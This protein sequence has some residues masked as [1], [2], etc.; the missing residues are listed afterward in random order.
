M[1]SPHAPSPASAGDPGEGE[2]RG[3]ST[4]S[5]ASS[6]GSSW[7]SGRSNGPTE[8]R[9]DHDETVTSPVRSGG[10][11]NWTRPV[12]R[13][14]PSGRM[15]HSTSSDADAGFA[16]VGAGASSSSAASRSRNEPS[17]TI[18]G[19]RISSAPDSSSPS[20]R[21]HDASSTVG[22]SA[23]LTTRTETTSP[24]SRAR[25]RAES[26]EAWMLEITAPSTSLGDQ[27][28]RLGR[29]RPA[30]TTKI[31]SATSTSINE[32]ALPLRS[33]QPTG[34]RHGVR[35]VQRVRTALS[36]PS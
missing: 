27:F 10:A 35:V 8:S 23:D 22:P 29:A 16:S 33:E 31:E 15:F 2:A 5:S 17:K 21:A 24:R 14:V 32:N 19:R 6:E 36:R 30:S 1:A 34:P 26:R 11:S 28:V 3:S 4:A 20:L 13:T 9:P 7:S 25:A 12:L 18:S